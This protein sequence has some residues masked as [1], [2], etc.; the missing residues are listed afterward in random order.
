MISI[1]NINNGIK[2][3]PLGIKTVILVILIFDRYVKVK[4]SLY[5][6]FIICVNTILKNIL[7]LKVI[8]TR[9]EGSCMVSRTQ[10]LSKTH[11]LLVLQIWNPRQSYPNDIKKNDTRPTLVYTQPPSWWLMIVI[12]F[13][14]FYFWGIRCIDDNQTQ[15]RYKKTKGH[16]FLNPEIQHE[17]GQEVWKLTL[18]HHCVIGVLMPTSCLLI[19]TQPLR[20]HA[21]QNLSYQTRRLVQGRSMKHI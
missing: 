12:H 4:E 3:I 8:L 6:Q 17:Q 21:S 9:Y 16:K 11:T 15:L 7:M 10:I 1:I 14:R 19:S 20:G 2:N 18:D 13:L 5:I